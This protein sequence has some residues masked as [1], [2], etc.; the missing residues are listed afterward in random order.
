MSSLILR[1]YDFFK[2]G[3]RALA[4]LIPLVLCAL[5]VWSALGLRLDSDIAAFLMAVRKGIPRASSYTRT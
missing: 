2:N 5:F 3:R 1:I 4:F